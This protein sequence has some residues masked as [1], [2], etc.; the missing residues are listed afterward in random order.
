MLLA[1]EAS[2]GCKQVSRDGGQEREWGDSEMA[3]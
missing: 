1:E 2:V 3:H